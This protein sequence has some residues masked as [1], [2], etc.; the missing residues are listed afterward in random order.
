M[1]IIHWSE[2]RVAVLEEMWRKGYS[3]RQ[4]AQQLGG[5]TRNAVIGKANR[6]GLSQR[7]KTVRRLP[8]AAPIRN[9]RNCQWPHGNPGE[10]SFHLCGERVL[11]GKPYCQQHC[12]VAYRNPLAANES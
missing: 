1:N 6:M 8:I 2:D 11:N 7:P 4:I 3:A 9:E 10:E 12:E 5:V